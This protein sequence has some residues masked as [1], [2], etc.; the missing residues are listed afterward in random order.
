MSLSRKTA[1]V[2]VYEHPTRFAPDKSMFQIMAESIRGALDDAGLSIKDVDG[3]CTAGMGMGAMGIVGFCDY[4]N[5]TPNFVDG[6][7]IGGSSFV[8]H[9]AHA[10]AAINA[11]L[12]D[13]AVIVYGSTAASAR[14]AIG[15]GGGGGGGD[16]CDQYEFPYGP[17]TVGAY[18]MIAQRHMHDYGTTPEQL[19]E[20]AVTMRHHASMNPVA[21]YRDPITVDD[22]LASRVISSPLHLLDCCIISDG[23]GA[24][25][26]TSAE[27]ARDLKKRPVYLLGA[28]E[29]V[30]HAARGVR[31]FLEIAAAQSGRLAF[32]RAGVS[33]RDVDLAMVYDSFTITVIVTLENLGFCKRGEGGAFVSGGRLRFDGDFPLNTD[34]GGLSSNH[35]G[36]RGMFL[37]IE[38]ARQL[39][40][41]AGPR[42]VRDCRTA[43][44]HGTGGNLGTRHSGATLILS[45]QAG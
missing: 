15:T 5:L 1:I 8:A 9:T 11:G 41:E 44:V 38:A 14:F 21:K 7:N 28:G 33:H 37:L 26:V 18:A 25:V 27:R 36:M 29:A 12:C 13:V 22:V 10:A 35:P 31:D 4:M 42:Q 32:E 6:T 16:P 30:R 43:L 2:G 3:L 23:G 20:I 24:L 34:G 45:N 39:R 40:G 19:A 17:T